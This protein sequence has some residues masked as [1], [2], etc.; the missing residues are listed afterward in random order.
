VWFST[1]AD[2]FS[3]VLEAAA[4]HNRAI[5][6]KCWPRPAGGGGRLRVRAALHAVPGVWRATTSALPRGIEAREC[7]M[8]IALLLT[9]FVDRSKGG[10][11]APRYRGHRHR[12]RGQGRAVDRRSMR[13]AGIEGIA[14]LFGA[15]VGR[16][17]SGTY[18]ARAPALSP[19]QL[20]K[21]LD[22]R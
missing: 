22:R 14:T 7:L 10:D 20:A 9:D 12:R 1:K 18:S 3:A 4:R 15:G 13:L 17:P 21:V 2:L 8:L 16:A 6:E 5:A 19:G 11:T